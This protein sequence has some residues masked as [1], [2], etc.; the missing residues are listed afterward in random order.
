MIDVMS[1][2]GFNQLAENHIAALGMP[3]WLQH[4][5]RRKRANQREVPV[6]QLGERV[7]RL[8]GSKCR[9][10]LRPFLLIKR[11]HHMVRFSERL[12]IAE[13]ESQLTVGQMNEN[14]AWAPFAGRG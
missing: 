10:R 4:L 11:L 6:A 9:I 5:F 7:E 13:S 8:L 1:G 2:T 12:A 14:L 3:H